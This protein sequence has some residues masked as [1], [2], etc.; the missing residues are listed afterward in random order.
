MPDPANDPTSAAIDVSNDPV[1]VDKIKDHL[2]NFVT[3]FALDAEPTTE[4]VVESTEPVIES[5]EPVVESTEPVTDP[6]ETTTTNIPEAY[7]R[8]AKARGWSDKEIEDFGNTQPELAL[9]TLERIHTSRVEE[10]NDWANRGRQLK[11]DEGTTEPTE[12]P[13]TT[14]IPIDTA[15]LIETYGNEE[16]IKGIVDPINKAIA[17]LSPVVE[18]ARV[19]QEQAV[20]T[21]QEALMTTID[22][23]F[24]AESMAPYNELY[25]K[26]WDALTDTQRS[27]RD[28]V[29]EMA[30][31]LVAGARAQGRILSVDN[32]LLLA[33]DATTTTMK[34]KIIRDGV[35]EQVTERAASLTLK[36]NVRGQTPDPAAPPRNREELLSRADGWLAKAFG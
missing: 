4:P 8:S 2:E 10:V 27:T 13:A 5:T 22:K 28:S 16:L 3:D 7:R 31:A 30:D 23:F 9:Q 21:R 29:L 15:A 14:L 1:V 26:T 20:K 35:R 11:A 34:E 24:G 18:D 12:T 17:S 33:H 25:G 19:A 6:V 32:A 36:P